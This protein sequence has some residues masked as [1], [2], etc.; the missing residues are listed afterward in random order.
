MLGEPG[1]MYEPGSRTNIVV[2]LVTATGSDSHLM[3]R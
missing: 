3:N 1:L 2:E